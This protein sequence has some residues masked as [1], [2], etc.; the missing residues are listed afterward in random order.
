MPNVT[1][2]IRDDQ[3]PR[4]ECLDRL[5][6]SCEQLC[7]GILDALPENIHI[8]YVAVSH[9][10]GHPAFADI[11]YRMSA[12]RTPAV[13]EDFMQQLEAAIQ[14]HTGLVPRIR[15]FAYAAQAIHAL[16]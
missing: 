11:R 1:L 5:T 12:R 15:C 10:K 7:I 4:A 16:N 3:M 8:I 2:F 9:G 6:A 14:A 13:M